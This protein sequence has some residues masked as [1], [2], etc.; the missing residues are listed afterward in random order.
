MRPILLGLALVFAKTTVISEAAFEEVLCAHEGR[1]CHV[2]HAREVAFGRKGGKS[3]SLHVQPPG[4]D[5]TV[6]SFKSDPAPGSR[7]E[8]F[9]SLPARKERLSVCVLVRTYAEQRYG[10]G[11]LL[12]SLVAAA[13]QSATENV[14]VL[15]VSVFDTNPTNASILFHSYLQRE[16]EHLNVNANRY[17][18][19]SLMVNLTASI[20][21]YKQNLYGYDATDLALELSLHSGGSCDYYLFT[22]GDNL[23]ANALFQTPATLMRQSIDMIAFDFVSHHHHNKLNSVEFFNSYV[24]LGAVLVSRRAIQEANATFVGNRT[25]CFAC[26][27][28]FFASLL[29]RTD[30]T[31]R[32]V[33]EVLFLHQ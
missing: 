5:C 17:A 19:F 14:V 2:K 31:T 10:I 26:D 12:S 23:Y 18:T 24:D 21:T 27:W 20:P 22:N 6:A 11:A 15:N 8:C 32:I 7:K 13:A 28:Y 3:V 30:V 29:N 33:R 1:F 4:I 16:L 25:S 9:I